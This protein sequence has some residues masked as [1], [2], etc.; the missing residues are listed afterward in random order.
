MSGF[1]ILN[2]SQPWHDQVCRR[3]Q[4]Y[5]MIVHFVLQYN[6]CKS[7]ISCKSA[8]AGITKAA[9]KR[10]QKLRASEEKKKSWDPEA[11]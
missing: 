5:S 3:F 9:L 11:K 2:S 7:T 10:K 8:E 1:L 4:L 6:V